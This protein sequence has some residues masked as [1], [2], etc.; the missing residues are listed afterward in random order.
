MWC[1]RSMKTPRCERGPL[2][3]PYFHR[4]I[5]AAYMSPSK[6]PISIKGSADYVIGYI[7]PWA[8]TSLPPKLR[9]DHFNCFCTVHPRGRHT[10][11]QN[12]TLRCDLYSNRPHLHTTSRVTR[13]NT[14]EA[15]LP[16]EHSLFH[17]HVPL[18]ATEVSLSQDRVCGTV[19]S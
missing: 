19:Y 2:S 15:H 1:E 11:R 17:A 12:T 4:T 9:V 14:T 18:S 7:V 16:T 5:G 8:N 6:V 10:D 3:Y 13:P